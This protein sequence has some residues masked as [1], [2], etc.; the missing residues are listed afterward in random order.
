MDRFLVAAAV[1]GCGGGP[2]G[3]VHGTVVMTGGPS[4]A[5][6]QG[7]AGTVVVTRGGRPLAQERVGAGQEFSF[8][9]HEGTYRLTVSNAGLPCVD[10]TVTVTA[11]TD[12][13]VTIVC[14]RK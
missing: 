7:T 1:A 13:Q 11:G 4:S 2:T 14:P 6:P 5:R 8:H 3:T 12:Q 10:D 9:L